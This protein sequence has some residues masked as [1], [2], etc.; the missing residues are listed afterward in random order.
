LKARVKDVE[1]RIESS[2]EIISVC[3]ALDNGQLSRYLGVADRESLGVIRFGHERR[4]DVYQVDLA[5]VPLRE[6]CLQ[7]LAHMRRRMFA[8]TKPSAMVAVG[9]MQGVVREARLYLEMFPRGNVYVMA[10]SG[11]AA[12][13]LH[14][15]LAGN[16]LEETKPIAVEGWGARL[17]PVE[18]RFGV[19][20][21]EHF[22]EARG[23]LAKQP[24]ALLMQKVVREIAGKND[25]EVTHDR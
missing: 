6:Q 19:S 11:G 10:T 20:S 16:M 8:E 1:I 18:Q 21:W 13:R 14:R 7:S 17:V 15:Y 5:L 12:E 4:V 24:Y 2:F 22:R 9:G 23:H 25:E 3:E